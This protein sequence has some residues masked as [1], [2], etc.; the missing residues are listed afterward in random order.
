MFDE[1]GDQC[2]NVTIEMD[3]FLEDIEYF[4][5]VLATRDP[6]VVFDTRSAEI[7]ILDSDSKCTTVILFH[8][9]TAM[10]LVQ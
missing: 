5:V 3:N 6:D 9:A 2:V 7:N 4:H 1:V 10:S 8:P